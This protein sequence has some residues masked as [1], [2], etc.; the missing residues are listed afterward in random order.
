[1]GL[2]ASRNTCYGFLEQ[3][4]YLCLCKLPLC[5][6][7]VFCSPPLCQWHKCEL[8]LCLIKQRKEPI[9]PKQKKITNVFKVR[10]IGS[11]FI[12]E[13]KRQELEGESYI[14]FSKWGGK[15]WFR[16]LKKKV[17]KLKEQTC[18]Q[19][20]TCSHANLRFTASDAVTFSTANPNC[21]STACITQ[22]TNYQVGRKFTEMY[23]LQ[24]NTII[25]KVLKNWFMKLQ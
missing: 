12:M 1:M 24:K 11:S 18:S 17:K 2:D 16:W 21:S 7:N 22:T 23:K 15:W 13:V 5:K 4:F 8:L 10:E 14:L 25:P 3:V 6:K 19:H 20:L 9:M